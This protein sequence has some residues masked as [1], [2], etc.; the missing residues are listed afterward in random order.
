MAV[1]KRKLSIRRT[2][3]RMK[4]KIEGFVKKIK[5]AYK[6]PK[7]G[8]LKLPH[9]KCFWCGYYAKSRKNEG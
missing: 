6:C 2:R 7:C 3:A 1:P 5:A 4:K 8:H 9:F